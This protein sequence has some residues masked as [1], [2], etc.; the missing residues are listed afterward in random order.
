MQVL[1]LRNLPIDATEREVVELCRPYGALL[2][3]KRGVGN[4]ASQAFAEFIAL[5]DAVRMARQCA[6]DSA[7][8]KAALQLRGRSVYVVFSAKQHIETRKRP[9]EAMAEYIMPC[10]VSSP[11]L[12]VTFEGL[13]VCI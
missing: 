6:D 3:V 5:E 13:P 7:S 10:A 11:V 4:L 9:A 2:Q 12:L 1:H 8:N